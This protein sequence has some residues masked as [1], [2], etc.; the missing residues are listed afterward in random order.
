MKKRVLSWILTLALLL[1]LMPAA[2]VPARAVDPERYKVLLWIPEEDNFYS[3]GSG[4]SNLLYLYKNMQQFNVT[5]AVVEKNS[6]PLTEQELDGVQLVYI[7]AVTTGINTENG[8]HI[9]NAAQMLRDFA[10]KGG[11]VI[12]NGEFGGHAKEGN[13]LLSELA[14]KMGGNFT[15]DPD[16][17][18]D[19][20]TYILNTDIDSPLMDGVVAKDFPAGTVGIITSTKPDAVWLMRTSAGTNFIVD[21][22]VG[23]G[24][25]TVLSDITFLHYARDNADYE[26]TVRRF[27]YNLLK[28]SAQHMEEIANGYKVTFVPNGGAG[29]M[30]DQEIEKNVATALNANAFTREGYVFSGWNTAADGSGTAYNEGQVIQPSASLTLYAQWEKSMVN[31]AYDANGGSGAMATQTVRRGT[32][33]ALTP[34]AFTRA[35]YSFERWNTAADGSGTDYTDAQTVTPMQNVKL[36]AVWSPCITLLA[37]D[38]SER[39]LVQNVVPGAPTTLRANPFTRTGCDFL[40]WNTV[41]DGSGTSY[42]DRADVG[43]VTGNLVLYAQWKVHTYTVRYN[44]NGG[45]G[46]MPDQAFACG[47]AQELYACSFGSGPQRFTGWALSPNGAAVYADRQ[48]VVDLTTADGGVVTLYAVWRG[49]TQDARVSVRQGNTGFG[50][51]NGKLG[52]WYQFRVPG[53]IYNLVTEHKGRTVTSLARADS[54]GV[55]GY[56]TVSKEPVNSVLVVKP[57]TPDIVVGGLDAAAREGYRSGEVTLTMTVERVPESP[58]DARHS[59]I[60]AA[61][62]SEELEFYEFSLSRSVQGAVDRDFRGET[63]G[64][65]T[66]YIPLEGEERETKVY[67]WHNGVVE[68]LPFGTGRGEYAAIEGG[69][70]AIHANKFSAYAI[71]T[72]TGKCPRDH[73]CPISAYTDSSPQAWYH[74]GVHWALA[75]GVMIGFPKQLFKPN[76]DISRAQIVMML[77]RMSGCPAG[78]RDCPF[79]DAQPGRWFSD[80]VRWA[81]DTGVVKGRSTTKFDPKAPITREEL[82][83]ILYRYTQNRNGIQPE[84]WWLFLTD[85]QDSGEISDWAYE[86]MSWA[87]F[88]KI[89]VGTLTSN[90]SRLLEPRGNASRA[91]T[92]TVIMRWWEGL[93]PENTRK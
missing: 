21:Q 13:A 2:V 59:A 19:D 76:D 74:D 34:N 9:L 39:K 12:L 51:A 53:D 6:G 14:A 80:A 35:G 25:I 57:D 64:N 37:N 45:V 83:A 22:P 70:L 20:R 42:A 47:T 67:R 7:S 15:I 28:D 55:R 1:T 46:E 66:V 63:A 4:R 82:A 30:A 40:G 26:A 75:E 60:R 81:A 68:T 41:A 3:R 17:S 48:S 23:Y 89:F 85:Y 5:V 44:A 77:W 27:L 79:T 43:V 65:I 29:T 93:L 52:D 61:A 16:K 24:H 33:V 69:W 58:A 49:E 92:A 84:S 91:Q 38:G 31:I 8:P 56:S 73:R 86:A 87:A 32:A 71:G 90:G 72:P 50:A 54:E 11:R 78:S 88:S 18:D 10:N 62:G 36:Y